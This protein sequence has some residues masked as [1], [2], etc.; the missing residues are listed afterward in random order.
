MAL[1]EAS[2]VIPPPSPG[3]PQP[4][5]G[6]RPQVRVSVVS[7]SA[8]ASLVVA[9]T[10]W[11]RSRRPSVELTIQGPSG[12]QVV[13][14]GASPDDAAELSRVLGSVVLPLGATGTAHAPAEA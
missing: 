2:Y 14:T 6:Q 13:L 10:A 9:V 4:S 12:Q 7:A 11:L 5:Y 8:L 3:T 1:A